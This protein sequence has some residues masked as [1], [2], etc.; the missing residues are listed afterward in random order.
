MKL[1]ARQMRF[2]PAAVRRKVTKERTRTGNVPGVNEDKDRR[3]AGKAR[4][5]ARRA[6][7]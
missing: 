7:R 6:A 5:R 3:L 4:I 2:V 1:E